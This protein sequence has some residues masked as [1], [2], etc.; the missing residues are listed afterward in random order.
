M[1]RKDR[2]NRQRSIEKRSKKFRRSQAKIYR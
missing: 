1:Q 2:E